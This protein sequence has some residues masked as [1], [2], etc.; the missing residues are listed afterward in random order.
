[1]GRLRASALPRGRQ[2]GSCQRAGLSWSLHTC[3]RSH[4]HNSQHGRCSRPLQGGESEVGKAGGSVAPST[5]QWEGRD[6][7]QNPWEGGAPRAK[8]G[9][10]QGGGGPAP[11]P[12]RLGLPPR[13]PASHLSHGPPLVTAPTS[14]GGFGCCS[15]IGTVC[16]HIAALALP[17]LCMSSGKLLKLSGPP[18]P[19]L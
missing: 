11:T 15:R 12:Q 19:H 8:P 10:M 2:A 13:P 16:A 1:M 4:P 6:W 14:V 3:I 5:G 7:S 18:R 9:G 17:T